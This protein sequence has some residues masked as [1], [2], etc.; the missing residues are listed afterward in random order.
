V[1]GKHLRRI[2]ERRTTSQFASRH[3]TFFWFQH[4][5]A[6]PHFSRQVRKILHQ[7]YPHRWIGRGGPRHWPAWSPELNHLGF[8]LWSYVKNIVYRSPIAIEEQLRGHV[9]E[10]LLQLLLKWLRILN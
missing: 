9:Q 3:S 6:L 10:A 1:N 8:F 2:F 4:T 5:G 7:H